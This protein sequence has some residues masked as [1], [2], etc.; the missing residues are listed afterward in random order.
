[1]YIIGMTLPEVYALFPADSVGAEIGVKRGANA[2]RMFSIIKPRK[3]HLIDPWGKDADHAYTAHEAQSIMQGFYEANV[4]WA[5][6]PEQGG[7]V[8]IVRDY[9]TVAAAT[10]P[11]HYFDWVYIDGLHDYE[12]VY[13]DLAAFDPKIRPGGFLFGD[14]YWDLSVNPNKKKKSNIPEDKALGMINGVN[15]FCADYDHEL[16]FVT[17]DESPKFF[18][19]KKNAPAASRE[20]MKQVLAVA[21]FVVEVENPRS[22]RT[23]LADTASADPA[24]QRRVIM[25]VADPAANR[26]ES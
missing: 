4:K 14:D 9:S 18:L 10:F 2:R 11:D 16:L 17:S 20:I 12:N 25:K 5:A 7:R 23:T 19:A 6:L 15:D 22:F 21:P 13:A 8:D 24:K 1:M 3:L 26:V